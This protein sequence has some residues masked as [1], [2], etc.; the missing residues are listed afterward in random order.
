MQQNSFK[1]KYLK[2]FPLLLFIRNFYFYYSYNEITDFDYPIKKRL[3]NGNYLVMTTQ[4]I[5]LYNEDFLSKKDILI[6]ESYAYQN[7]N[8][9]EAYASDIAQF[10]TNND[11]YIIC[12]IK[13]ETY[14]KKV[15][16][17]PLP[18][19]EQGHFFRGRDY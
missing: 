15:I 17:M 2:F 14:I 12:L 4:G 6:F 3:N 18:L 5:Y 1:T 19:K 9:D 11:G 8:N 7:I 10:S 16:K 13:N